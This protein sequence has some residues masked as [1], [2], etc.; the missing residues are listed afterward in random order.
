MSKSIGAV[1]AGL[2]TIVVLSSVTDTV[3]ES[4]GVFPRVAVQQEQ[5]FDAPWM[6]LLAL[7][8]RSV[9][10]A[11]APNRPMRHAAILGIVGIAPVWFT[12]LLLVLGLPC[13]LLGGKRRTSR[14]RT[15]RHRTRHTA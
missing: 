15:R 8:C 1:L 7:A 12:I 5:G 4:T 2:V 10:A 6:V 14:Q 11:L 9:Y 3:L 13:M